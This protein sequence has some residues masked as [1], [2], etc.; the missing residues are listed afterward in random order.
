MRWVETVHRSFS[1]SCGH[2]SG[3]TSLNVEVMGVLSVLFPFFPAWRQIFLLALG[4][5]KTTLIL[6][7]QFPEGMLASS[8]SLGVVVSLHLHKFAYIFSRT[9]YWYFPRFVLLALSLIY[10]YLY[11]RILVPPQ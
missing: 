11:S 7:S 4:L 10:I 1:H 3:C 8:E 2:Q 6:G 9:F 5:H